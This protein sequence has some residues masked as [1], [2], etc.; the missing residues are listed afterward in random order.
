MMIEAFLMITNLSIII[1]NY[2]P[3]FNNKNVKNS[4]GGRKSIYS[5]NN[6]TMMQFLM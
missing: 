4:N 1:Q 2:I 3:I 6:R 5:L